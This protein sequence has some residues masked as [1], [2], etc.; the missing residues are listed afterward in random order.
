M[1]EGDENITIQDGKT[2]KTARVS[3]KTGDARNWIFWYAYDLGCS[4]LK[5][6]YDEDR[7]YSEKIA[8]AVTEGEP[9]AELFK[10]PSSYRE[11]EPST[12]Y[13]AD[14]DPCP[15]AARHKQQDVNYHK[16]RQKLGL[17]K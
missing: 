1:Y 6:R 8:V 3:L 13:C 15:A 14:G 9:N 10:V 11:S 2:Y 7:G 4:I 16:L 17:E 5:Q 12:L